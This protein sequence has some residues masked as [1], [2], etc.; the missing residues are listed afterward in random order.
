[1][2]SDEVRSLAAK[3]ANAAKSTEQLLV[4]TLNAVEK[5][6]K[7]TEVTG[8]D[9]EKVA[10]KTGLV[11]DSISDIFNVSELQNDGIQSINSEIIHISD[12]VKANSEKADESAAAS[13][14]LSSQ[15]VLLNQR[16][17]EYVH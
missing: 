14:E 13:Q 10:G 5:G 8:H 4:K 3:S 17:G 6:K 2:D 16:I 12:S 9:L 1:M 11:I 15:A 7:I